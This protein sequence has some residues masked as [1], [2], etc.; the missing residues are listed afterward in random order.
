MGGT[1]LNKKFSSTGLEG[2]S[3]ED[4]GVQNIS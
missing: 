2:R 3:F 1:G 4:E